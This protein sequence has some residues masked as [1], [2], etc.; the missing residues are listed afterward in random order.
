MAKRT[1]TKI[2]VLVQVMHEL[3][4]D[5]EIIARVSSVPQRTVSDIANCR[6]C[7][8]STG[9]FNEV[10]ESYRFYLRKCLRDEALALGEAVLKRFEALAKDADLMTALSIANAVM[11]LSARNDG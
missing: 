2:A 11:A 5:Q 7:S 9:A 10:Q 6:G 4:F 3:G 1:E 8:A